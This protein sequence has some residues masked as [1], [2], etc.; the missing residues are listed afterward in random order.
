MDEAQATTLRQVQE[1]SRAAV[2]MTGLE[3]FHERD[4]RRA[5]ERTNVAQMRLRAISSLRFIP[6][7]HTL[8]RMGR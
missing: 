7:L 3:P 6:H 8:L 5:G 1:R 4:S 2:M